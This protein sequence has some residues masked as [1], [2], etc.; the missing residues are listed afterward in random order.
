MV[1]DSV[2]NHD[3]NS[4]KGKRHTLDEDILINHSRQFDNKSQVWPIPR[5]MEQV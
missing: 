1:Y 4:N 5:E 3:P 2:Q